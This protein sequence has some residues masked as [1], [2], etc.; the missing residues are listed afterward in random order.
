MTVGFSG[1]H[2]TGKSTLV[3]AFAEKHTAFTPVFTNVKGV[4]ERL[5]VDPKEDIPF[6]ERLDVQRHILDEVD[7]QYRRAGMLLVADRTPV[8]LMMYTLA[9]VQRQTLDDALETRLAA[10]IEDCIEVTNQHF[11]VIMIIPPAIAAPDHPLS[12]PQSLGYME[13]LHML[14]TGIVT[15]ERIAAAHF[16]LARDATDLDRRVGAVENMLA[17]CKARVMKHAADTVYH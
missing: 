14:A 12:A 1:S 3:K 13:H 7:H 4:Y 8:C 11:G 9:E 15:D 2:R 16:T 6:A 10:Y 5:G 17:V